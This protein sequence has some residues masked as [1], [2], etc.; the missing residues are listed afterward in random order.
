MAVCFGC[1]QSEGLVSMSFSRRSFLVATG[2]ALSTAAVWNHALA[3]AQT[4]VP[5]VDPLFTPREMGSPDAK[6]VVEEW[7]SLTCI[8]CAHFAENTFPQ[9]KANLIDTG[10]IRYVFHDF[11]TDQTATVAAMVARAL[12]VDRYEPFCAS[13]LSTLERW[14]YDREAN[15]MTELKKMAAF[16][17]M[18]GDVF[19]K[20][21][22]NQKLM[23]FILD[24]QNEA[25]AKY[26]IDSTPTFRFNNTLQVASAL[27]YDEF[28]KNL[29]KAG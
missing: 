27:S 20:T 10:K 18:P 7:F 13:L 23:Q 25:Q 21:V 22:A 16:A 14:A 11:P 26:N 24:G 8:H 6:V 9:V 17:G 28:V 19:D 2:A 4:T 29:A 1:H 12:P 5:P 15:P 3:A